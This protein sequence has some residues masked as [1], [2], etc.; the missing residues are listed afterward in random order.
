MKRA[1]EW[2]TDNHVTANLIM[3]L[4]VFGGVVSLVFIKVEIFPDLRLESVS[5]TMI[6]PGAAPDEVEESICVKIEEAVSDIQGIEKIVSEASEGRGSVTIELEPGED[7][8]RRQE[9][10][11]AA[12]D[13][14]VT[15]PE[16][17]E[18]P[19]VA[20]IERISPVINLGIYGDMDE[21]TL[22]EL[23]E[24]MRDELI[25]NYDISSISVT[26]VR[27]YEISVEVAEEKLREYNMTFDEISRAIKMGSIDLPGGKIRTDDGDILLRTKQEGKTARDY[28]N[29]VLRT[30]E[31]VHILRIKDVAEVKDGFEE[32]YM[33]TLF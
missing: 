31:K 32:S 1:I 23:T 28:E 22:S 11:K 16:N 5:V 8:S 14:I 2:M 15:F 18:K 9:E 29:I 10:I 24:K 7:V 17:A 30:N 3:L 25:N 19:V 20:Q 13:R 33:L 21:K 26:G 4:L 27:D 12:V 6:Y